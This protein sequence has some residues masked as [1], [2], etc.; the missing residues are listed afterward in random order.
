MKILHLKLD[1]FGPFTDEAI[2]LSQG[3][4]GLHM[5]LGSN[6]AGKTSAL[7]GITQL[8]YGIPPKSTD[9]FIHG[10]PDMRL[11]ATLERSDGSRLEF[12]RQ[13]RNK[14]P[15][16]RAD[17][18]TPLDASE[19]DRFLDKIDENLF[20]T[21][22]GIDHET[23]IEG[24]HEMVRGGGQLGAILTG[25]AGLVR[26]RAVQQ[27]LQKEIDDLF[28]PKGKRQING[29]IS[30]YMNSRSEIKKLQLSRETWSRLDQD[31]R[32]A[33]Q[34]RQQLED[35][36]REKE[37]ES[38]RLKRIRAALPVF[39]ERKSLLSEL[40]EHRDTVVLPT[41]FRNRRHKAEKDRDTTVNEMERAR[42]AIE[43]ARSRREQ[44]QPPD[45]LLAFENEIEDLAKRQ[46]G[47]RKGQSQRPALTS[48]LQ[49]HERSASEILISLGRS[50]DLAEAESLR[51]RVDEPLRI[52]Q[53]AR[54]YTE[55]R[56]RR[57][58]NRQ[59]V[60][61]HETRL[62][63]LRRDLQALGNLPDLAS[64]RSAIKAALKA[65]D[66]ETR[67]AA[68]RNELDS[69]DQEA[70]LALRQLPGWSGSSEDLA[71]LSV[72]LPET[73]TRYE[74]AIKEAEASVDEWDSD[75]RRIEAEIDKLETRLRAHA[76]EQDVPTEENLGEARHRRDF[77]WALVRK[78][79]LDG[80]KHPNG[81]AEFISEVAPGRSLA[82]AYERTVVESDSVADRLRREADRVAR[83][84]EWLTQLRQYTDQLAR[85]RE[86][87][88][89]ARGRCD[90]LGVEWNDILQPL[91]ISNLSPPEL[92]S[93]LGHR[94][95][96]LKQFREV[97][98]RRN[99]QDRL[100][101]LIAEHR[102]KLLSS[103]SPLVEPPANESEQL[104][105]LL[106]FAQDLLAQHEKKAKKRDQ[107]RGRDRQRGS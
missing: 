57:D 103:V 19:L 75:L 9:N 65:G 93:W 40:E 20:K 11:G 13:K 50:D 15:L 84:A 83:K 45:S 98:E 74:A 54:D 79:W 95:G 72:P 5:I 97:R 77:G 14:T 12:I 42:K 86:A 49:E 106:E 69:D 29:L 16:F 59:T 70:L 23:L 107:T 91:K 53:L 44:I 99:E 58:G 78:A 96:L 37:R 56:T 87:S 35:R 33:E 8:F 39:S 2:D 7:R 67:Y 27:E 100:A 73:L 52:A 22:F 60:L 43:Q 88:E 66:L 101:C 6:E 80:E 82:D 17:G 31:L 25:V 24:G 38:S 34:K 10:H 102:S 62:A 76:L 92:R 26:L 81:S 32:E 104:A 18:K 28:L 4:H 30:D 21:L 85:A 61:K 63:K 47:H 41:D 64:V 3:R 105:S 68:A 48:S 51:P 94:D 89:E 71:K 55:L 36:R 46:E 1:A 90:R